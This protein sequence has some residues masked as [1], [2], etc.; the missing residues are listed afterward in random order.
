ME[1]I[2][3]FIE[4]EIVFYNKQNKKFKSLEQLIKIISDEYE[5]GATPE[6]IRL[7]G[8]DEFGKFYKLF[9]DF[10][11][12]TIQELSQE[13]HKIISSNR[14]KYLGDILIE[15]GIITKNQLRQA[16]QEQIK[17]NSKE[18]IG[19]ILIKL[20]YCSAEQIIK[21]LSKQFGIIKKD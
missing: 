17:S 7:K 11:S 20:G 14:Q 9:L 21:T 1:N 5:K 10:N 19:E 16:L 3:N 4:G 8:I 12:F 6:L 13:E 18:K 15:A 2:I